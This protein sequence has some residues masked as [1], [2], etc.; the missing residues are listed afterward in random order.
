MDI[1]DVGHIVEN[2]G[3]VGQQAGCQKRQRSVL[4]TAGNQ[5]T[6]EGMPPFDQESVQENIPH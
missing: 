3:L 1:T 2:N 4:I 5:G 6:R